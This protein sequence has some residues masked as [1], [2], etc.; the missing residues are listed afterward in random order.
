MRTASSAP[1]APGLAAALRRRLRRRSGGAARA[2]LVAASAAAAVLLWTSSRPGDVFETFTSLQVAQSGLAPPRSQTLGGRSH[3][4][5]RHAS[6]ASALEG[7]EFK[8]A[9]DR[10]RRIQLGLGPDDP[11]PEEG[12]AVPDVVPDVVPKSKGD[13]EVAEPAD[14]DEEEAKKWLES[15]AAKGE[16]EEQ[17][18]AFAGKAEDVEELKPEEADP[19]EKKDDSNL[20]EML[21]E[22]FGKV[23]LPPLGEVG[24]TFGIVI[25]LVIAYT[26]FVAVVD[27]GAQSVFGQLFEEFYKAARPEQPSM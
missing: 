2:A 5:A 11:L 17:T 13:L 20:L 22:D 26:V 7:D 10:I 27:S 25:G 24:G 9:R 14:K 23:T 12:A 21:T 4:V 3:G 6:K 18:D 19:D 1:E 8:A 15:Q 16:A